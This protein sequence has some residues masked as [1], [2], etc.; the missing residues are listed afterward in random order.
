M[1]VSPDALEW[2]KQNS[3]RPE[4]Q[5]ILA[6][7]WAMSNP[8]RPEAQQIIQ[9]Y[10]MQPQGQGSQLQ[11][12]PAQQNLQ[13]RLNKGLDP[14]L[15]MDRSPQELNMLQQAEDIGSSPVQVAAGE[16]L[17]KLLGRPAA[18]IGDYLMQKAVGM[19]NFI[20]GVGEKL[21]QAGLI[22][23]KGMMQRQAE[24]GLESAGQQIGD[25]ASKIPGQIS[26]DPVANSVASIADRSITPEGYTRPESQA[27]VNKVLNKAQDF[28]YSE[29]ISGPEM[30]ARR[31]QA[32]MDAR[33]AGAYRNNPA[34]T[35]KAQLAS[36]EQ[37][38]YSQA[39]KDAYSKSFPDQ[40]NDLA[41]ADS[42]YSA[43]SKANTGLNAPQSSS[44]YSLLKK[45]ALPVA[46]GA[47]GGVPGAVAGA[48][49]STPAGQSVTGRAL[50]G[51]SKIA[52]K[53][54]I[55]SLPMDLRQ[56]F[57]KDSNK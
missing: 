9:K 33:A 10:S 30:A 48:V 16:G 28:A 7:D 43:L 24:S 41:N 52:E 35:L 17:G 42:M 56:L 51:A 19:K 57:G 4:A 45:L 2:A 21:A 8:D 50:I 44:Y 26:Q 37:S 40:P 1:P 11:L 23:T 47:A 39:L 25:L 49:L 20:P 12:S 13:N 36:A 5:Q 46:G 14:R 53:P 6:K 3:D 27:M 15:Q 31:A 54:Y 22:G 38:G 29:P 32:G 18:K 34:Q 55:N